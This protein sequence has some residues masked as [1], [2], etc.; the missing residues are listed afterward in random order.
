MQ[1][2]GETGVGGSIAL[3][4]YMSVSDRTS[5]HRCSVAEGRCEQEDT[6]M[7]AITKALG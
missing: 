3:K 7:A 5:R 1:F 2:P 4:T 6:G